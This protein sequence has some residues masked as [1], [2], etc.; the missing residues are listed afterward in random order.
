MGSV[1]KIK[2]GCGYKMCKP[3]KGG[4]TPKHKTKERELRKEHAK[5]INFELNAA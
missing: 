1:Y 3:H 2:K 4:Y 5:E